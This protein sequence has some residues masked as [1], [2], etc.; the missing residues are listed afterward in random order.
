MDT[1]FFR[2][3]YFKF[4]KFLNL[5]D[6]FTENQWN[7]S[8]PVSLVFTKIS[9]FLSS[10]SIHAIDKNLVFQ[11]G[12]RAL[13]VSMSH[14]IS[15]LPFWFLI[16]CSSHGPDANQGCCFSQNRELCSH[17]HKEKYF[18]LK[19]YRNC[20][21]RAPINMKIPRSGCA[22]HLQFCIHSSLNRAKFTT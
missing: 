2:I 15:V 6:Q 17:F 4:L 1:S 19:K 5:T 12:D 18:C 14:W 7:W 11:H 13:M 10:F 16:T 22:M 9:L 8:G 3:F 21:C 20:A